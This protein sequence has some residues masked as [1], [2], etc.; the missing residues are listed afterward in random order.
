MPSTLLR[1]WGLATVW[2]ENV[3][4]TED[5]DLYTSGRWELPVPRHTRPRFLSSVVPFAEG[6]SWRVFRCC[7]IMLNIIN[8][9]ALELYYRH[10]EKLVVQY[11][12]CWSLIYV[13]E[14][15]ARAERLEKHRRR[16]TIEAARGRQVPPDWDEQDPWS[17]VFTEL[18][19]DTT[20]WADRVHHPAAAWIASGSKGV[21]K[22]ASE[23]AVITHLPGIED[24][25]EPEVEE[26]RPNHR[27]VI[28]RQKMKQRRAQDREELNRLR[29][30]AGTA[31]KEG[32][33][34]K[35]GKAKG[36][37]KGKDQS[38][39]PLCFSW[40]SGSGPCGSLA[41]GEP[42]ACSIKR[43]RKC[44]KCLSPSRRRSECPQG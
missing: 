1:L 25:M 35:K 29:K 2:E 36:G 5:E 16:L 12:Q 44:R 10:I 17:C 40:D 13:A 19:K 30:S 37:G 34:N 11:P 21:P 20:Y 6:V 32:E 43:V 31:V 42:C 38:G 23:E 27:K 41:P 3:E 28:K 22:V 14:D 4:S 26:H 15:L 39:K 8:L 24:N 33:Q 9:A 7:A 18:V